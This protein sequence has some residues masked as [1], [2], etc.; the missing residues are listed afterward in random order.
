VQWDLAATYASGQLVDL[1]TEA[2]DEFPWA[3]PLQLLPSSVAI[4]LIHK[5]IKDDIH[6]EQ[7]W[8]CTNNVTM[9]L[10]RATIVAM[11]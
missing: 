2:T 3:I 1:Y 4:L 9:M 11:C 10:V 6:F 7:D 8:Q 5:Q